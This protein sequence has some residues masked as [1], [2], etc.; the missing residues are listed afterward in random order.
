[1]KAARG[2]SRNHQ[3]VSA[4]ALA[5]RHRRVA[6]KRRPPGL[7]PELAAGVSFP[8]SYRRVGPARRKRRA[9]A[10]LGV[11]AAQVARLLRV[12]VVLGVAVAIVAG[13]VGA[14]RTFAGS[15]LFTVRQIE[16]EGVAQASREEL[17]RAL[18]QGVAGGLWQ[19]D[20]GQ[21]RRALERHAW[22][23]SAEVTRVLPDTLRVVIAERQPFALARRSTGAVVWVDRDGVG[24]GER[25]RFR[26]ETVLPLINGLE[27]SDGEAAGEANRHR[28]LVY[29]QLLSELDQGEPRLS[30][31]V[32]EVNLGELKDVR[33]R[34]A[35][36]R[37][38]VILGERDFRPRLAAALKVLN[39]IERKDLA[40]LGLLRASDAERLIKGGRIAYLNATRPDR[41][42]V[43]LAQ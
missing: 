16:L 43:G 33:L 36:Q 24:L 13:L 18:R 32:D 31:A 23:R 25:N 30:E 5:E 12:C 40:T 34:L 21:L 6:P 22:V 1:M 42:I 27:E 2:S 10:S 26:T 38:T 28:L 39:G 35:D 3:R 9:R 14:Y 29:Q 15:S 37:I 20:L 11:T 8:V 17:M 7:P 41:V 4:S 19:A